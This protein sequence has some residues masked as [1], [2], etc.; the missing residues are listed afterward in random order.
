MD[1]QQLIN[2]ITP[3]TYQKLK[4]AVELGKWADGTALTAEQKEHC[5]QAVIAYDAAHKAEEDRVGYVPS[6]ESHTKKH[7]HCG[8]GGGEDPLADTGQPKPLKWS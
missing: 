6:K 2:S 3:E 8:S 1:F 4:Q 5:L 7:N